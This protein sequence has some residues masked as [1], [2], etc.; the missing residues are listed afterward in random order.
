MCCASYCKT[1][2]CPARRGARRGAAT[3]VD[4]PATPFPYVPAVQSRASARAVKT[5]AHAAQAG[6]RAAVRCARRHG[7]GGG[8]GAGAAAAGAASE[9]W[10]GCAAWAGAFYGT[11]GGSARAAGGVGVA[12]HIREAGARAGQRAGGRFWRGGGLQSAARDAAPL[13]R[14]ASASAGRQCRHLTVAEQLG[15]GGRGDHAGV[16]RHAAVGTGPGQNRGGRG[17][18]DHAGARGLVAGAAGSPLHHPL[19]LGVGLALIVAAPVLQ[20]S[21]RRNDQPRE[22]ILAWATTAF[23][24]GE[25]TVGALGVHGSVASPLAHG[26]RVIAYALLYQAVFDA[27]IR[28][29]FARIQEAESRLRES[30]SRL[31]RVVS[32]MPDMVFLKDADG[33]YLSV[34]PVFE[35]FIGRPEHQIVGRNDFDLT[36]PAQARQFRQNDQRAMQTRQPLVYEETLTFAE[37]GYQGRFETIKTPIRDLHGRVTGVLGVCRDI[38]ERKRAAQEIER[39][40]FYDALTGL[41]NRRLLLDRLQRSIATCQ[42]THK[43]GA[44][45]FIDLDNFKDLNDTLGHDMGDQLLAQV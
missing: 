25:I 27:G 23:A 43:L 42:R 24:C 12:A 34:N 18:R 35:R 21:P 32:A 19:A 36:T 39:L 31:A 7:G 29:P 44:L 17:G 28:R 2:H 11:G 14:G 15:A 4:T 8:A 20:R 30:E 5:R 40:A 3:V 9:R 22:R 10:R 13:R 38:T 16:P 37:D 26:L 33:V 41:P 45:L 6:A 1:E